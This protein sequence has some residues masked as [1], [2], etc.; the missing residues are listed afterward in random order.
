MRVLFIVKKQRFGYSGGGPSSGLYNS[1]KFVV[2]ML[3]ERLQ[4]NAKLAL[5]TDNNDI[6]RFV[7]EFRP[8]V[9]IIEALWVE[10]EKFRILAKLHPHVRWVV[11][12]HSA[13]PFLAHEGMALDWLFRYFGLH[14][15]EVGCNHRKTCRDLQMLANELPGRE[16]SY[17]PN[18]Y[19]PELHRRHH[20][21]GCV[22][23]IACFGAIRPLKNQLIQA[24]AAVE[25]AHVA[26]KPLHFHINTGRI[27]CD[28]E[29]ILR[30]IRSL[31]R[32][33]P[34]NRLIEH[35]WLERDDFIATVRKMDL[36]LQCS[37]S[38]TF[39]IVT[40]DFVMNDVPVVVS[41]EISW[42]DQ[43]FWADNTNSLDIATKIDFAIGGQH[44]HRSVDRLR[45][46]DQLSIIAW[47]EFLQTHR[48]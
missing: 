17:L 34:G 7:A 9:V 39:N 41:K 44:R 28:G 31:F 16:V 48:H 33:L 5:A 43:D 20:H 22:L 14:H 1:A 29:P 21:I 24:V 45:E 26:G 27:E 13:M 47:R 12:N 10:P 46:R 18:Y 42:V 6:D 35:P 2:D 32:N 40:A 38:E 30:N 23:N 36:G 19:P 37:F 4:V 8:R 25:Y 11:R 15:V 3:N